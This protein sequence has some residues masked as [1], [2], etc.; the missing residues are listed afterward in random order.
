MREHMMRC[1]EC[2]E[3]C[4]H[5]VT[6]V[7]FHARTTGH[8]GGGSAGYACP[9]CRETFS[10]W[11]GLKAHILSTGHEG[12]DVK[13]EGTRLKCK[14]AAMVEAT[15][16]ADANP[17]FLL[18]R[19]EAL[20]AARADEPKDDDSASGSRS[21]DSKLLSLASR[22]KRKGRRQGNCH[23]ERLKKWKEARKAEIAVKGAAEPPVD[24]WT[25]VKI[26]ELSASYPDPASVP[27]TRKGSEDH[28]EEIFRVKTCKL[29]NKKK[30][31]NEALFVKVTTE[32]TSA[33]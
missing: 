32:T 21:E 33:Q 23:E 16:A 4:G 19:L 10:K 12:G 1:P 9:E 15:V 11:A 30:M 27:M 31:S 18:W 26:T 20:T 13:T 22:S 25:P 28:E 8:A 17:E 14:Y 24:W 6:D 7:V 3:V 2:L 5:S 29:V